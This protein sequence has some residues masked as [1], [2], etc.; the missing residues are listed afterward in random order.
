M[1]SS[2]AGSSARTVSIS[3]TCIF[4][5]AIFVRN[6]GSGQNKPTAS[7]FIDSV[8]EISSHL[9]YDLCFVILKSIWEFRNAT[10]M[11]KRKL[12]LPNNKNSHKDFV[13]MA[14]GF[15]SFMKFESRF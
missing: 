10:P 1:S 7:N 13:K 3:P 5:I 2:A 4:S 6:T 14:N 12:V 9:F 11:Y 8:S 15:L